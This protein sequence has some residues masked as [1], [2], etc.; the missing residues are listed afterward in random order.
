[1]GKI[2]RS[3]R[4][5]NQRHELACLQ[6]Q[7]TELKQELEGR[8]AMDRDFVYRQTLVWLE[9]EGIP[10]LMEAFVAPHKEFIAHHKDLEIQHRERLA[11]SLTNHLVNNWEQIQ[12]AKE[13]TPSEDAGFEGKIPDD[14]YVMRDEMTRDTPGYQDTGNSSLDI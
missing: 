5:V 2:K 13:W 8:I 6:K 14:I 12:R 7:N 10:Y 9:H 4:L 1:M 11:V 3:E